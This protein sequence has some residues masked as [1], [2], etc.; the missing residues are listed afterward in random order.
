MYLLVHVHQEHTYPGATTPFGMVQLSP[1]TRQSFTDWE[2][3]AGYD[4]DD[5]SIIGFSHTHLTG[6]GIPDLADILFVPITKEVP[7]IP[8][9][10]E[11]PNSGYRSRFSHENESA[12]P[13]YYSVLL[14]DYNVKAELTATP[15]TGVH[16]YSYPKSEKT[17][18]LVDVSFRDPIMESSFEIISDTEI[19]GFRKSK[20]WSGN[21]FQYFVARFSQPIKSFS[22]EN[23]GKVSTTDKNFE[24]KKIVAVLDFDASEKEVVVEVALSAVSVESARKN[25]EAESTGF[26]FNKVKAN[27]KALWNQHLGKVEVEDSNEDK[28]TIFLHGFVSLIISP[29]LIF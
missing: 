7:L 22:V 2:A 12:E 6:T 24:G 14:E 16:R 1:D 9:S 17:S 28:K 13:G 20:A 15:R 26:D 27:A 8:G 23:D 25:L 5:K 18:V 4:Y 29:K 19:A 10:L 3:C 11:K 21:Q